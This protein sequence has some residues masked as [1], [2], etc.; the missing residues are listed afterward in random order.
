MRARE[1]WGWPTSQRLCAARTDAC[2]HIV[3]ALHPFKMVNSR[4]FDIVNMLI[5]RELNLINVFF[6]CSFV[7]KRT[8]AGIGSKLGSIIPVPL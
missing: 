4:R 5:V 2:M 3:A 6:T 7:L 1:S 8:F